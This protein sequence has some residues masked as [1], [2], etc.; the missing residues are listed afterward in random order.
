MSELP[1]IQALP[2]TP[3]F[4]YEAQTDDGQ[5][6][7]G[8]IEAGNAEQAMER[9]QA[10]HLRVVEIVPTA[11][12]RRTKPLTG[13]GFAAF[14]QQLAQLAG[15]GLPVEQGLRLIAADMR[16][17]RLA[18]T[19]EQLAAELERGTPLDQAFEKFGPQF[20]PLYSR[21]IRAGVKSGNLSA[22]LLNLGRHLEMTDRLRSTL[23]RTLSYPLFV[24]I[25]LG[26][27]LVFLGYAVLPQFQKIYAGYGI[28]LPWA[29]TALLSLS[30]AAPVLLIVLLALVIGGPLAWGLLRKTG[31]ANAVVER[32]VLPMPLVG[33]V[34]KFNLVARWCDAAKLGVDAG[35]DLPAAVELAGDATQSK[36][37][38]N[39]GLLLIDALSGGR[40]LTTAET[41]L[42]PPS[43]PAAM[44]FASGFHDL[45]TT[46]RSLSEMYERQ[47]ELRLKALPGILT[48]LLVV[49]LALV[50]GF[51]IVSLLSPL[52]TL[53]DQIFHWLGW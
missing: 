2:A 52:F 6:L 49:V 44:Q 39:D 40:P 10:M 3:R 38:S 47:A 41:H 19:V 30:D 17:G 28:P 24:L 31:H 48:P 26:F 42:L 18:R 43:I 23:W 36:R 13:D 8:D 7:S 35:L 9:L 32:L 34:L 25:T 51:V 46:L 12:E 22:V 50:I 1:P 33:P 14:N 15:A 29:T 45:R 53:L 11:R 21:L 4:G 27:L 5:R 16:T 37:L 20:P